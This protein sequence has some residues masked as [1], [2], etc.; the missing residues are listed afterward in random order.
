MKKELIILFSIAIA[1]S[2]R[3]VGV[4]QIKGPRG[5]QYEVYYDVPYTGTLCAWAEFNDTLSEVGWGSLTVRG[6][7]ADASEA[8][9]CSGIAEA[10]L[11]HTRISQHF[12]V[13]YDS[14]LEELGG[15]LPLELV[16][17]FEESVAW[18]RKMATERRGADAYWDAVYNTLR[19]FDGLAEGYA[20]LRDPRDDEPISVLQF[21]VLQAAGDLDDLTFVV[22]KNRPA[23]RRKIS[24]DAWR[25]LH[26]HCTGLIFLEEDNADVYVAHDTWSAYNTMNRILKDYEV[27]SESTTA[28]ATRWTFSSNA[29]QLLS[30]DDFWVLNSGLVVI[31]TTLHTWNT[32]LYDEYCRPESVLSWIRVNAA[33]MVARN[34]QEWAK[35]FNI[36]NSWTYNN[37]YMVVDTNRFA[38]GKPPRE[39]FLVTTEQVPGH[40]VVGDRTAELVARRW[41]PSINTP[42]FE[43]VYNASGYPQKVEETQ[44][45]YWSYDKCARHLIMKRDVVNKI[46]SY[47]DFQA[48]MRNNDWSKDP[49]SNSDPAEAIL[50]RYDLRPV[51]CLHQGTMTMCPNAFGGTDAK[52]TNMAL[53]RRLAF[54]AISSPQYETQP[55]WE[56]GTERWAKIRY[57]GLPKVWKF[58]WVQF[59]PI[60]N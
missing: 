10:A 17:W 43:Q 11:T 15:T 50:S 8:H 6:N 41:I 53:A 31:E 20:Q 23:L 24:S 40:Y 44:C 14:L 28:A 56:F 29:G 54:D 22:S 45:D 7:N 42:F 30:M 37:Q 36:A 60:Q 51:E 38:R 13:T 34:G 57:D 39:G 19:R 4:S 55:A 52:T 16:A 5:Y 27:L 2:A 59:A 9:Y 1:V 25:D 33:N 49:L 18:T 35:Y 47:R 12:S 21:V 46:H 3:T 58:P 32:S 26:H 48:F